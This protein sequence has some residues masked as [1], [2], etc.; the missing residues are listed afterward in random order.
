[1]QKVTIYE[2]GREV[3]GPNMAAGPENRYCRIYMD[4][5]GMLGYKDL[6]RF[7]ADIVR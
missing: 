2:T 3:N 4:F 5:F 6:V 1:M 7:H